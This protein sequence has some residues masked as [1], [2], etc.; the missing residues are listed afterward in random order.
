M[1]AAGVP[2]P[3]RLIRRTRSAVNP[4]SVCRQAFVQEPLC[5]GRIKRHS[6]GH[7]ALVHHH[8]V[9]MARRGMAMVAAQGLSSLPNLALMMYNGAT[10]FPLI[11][12]PKVLR[13]TS[14]VSV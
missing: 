5:H 11:A 7:R 10:S 9:G 1:R 3:A 13:K 14:R 4:G 8:L 2:G 12:I 6:V